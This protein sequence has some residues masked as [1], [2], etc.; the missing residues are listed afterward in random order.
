MKL[1]KQELHMAQNGPDSNARKDLL[2][3]HAVA[4]FTLPALH[5]LFR[6]PGKPDVPLTRMRGHAR[7]TRRLHQLLPD[8]LDAVVEAC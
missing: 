4:P 6:Y 1:G 5:D 2:S 7:D 3:F 8:I